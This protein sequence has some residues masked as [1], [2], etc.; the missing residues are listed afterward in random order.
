[1]V[2][3]EQGPKESFAGPGKDLRCAPADEK[4]ICYK[5]FVLKKTSTMG[6]G[7][8]NVLVMK[9]LKQYSRRIPDAT[10]AKAGKNLRKRRGTEEGGH[11]KPAKNADPGKKNTG[12][13]ESWPK[14]KTKNTNN[15]Q[16]KGTGS[17]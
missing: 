13:H 15:N 2:P 17:C 1:M 11:N 9:V 5:V 6:G 3:G 12:I 16:G 14:N 4:M 7:R 10:E 8:A